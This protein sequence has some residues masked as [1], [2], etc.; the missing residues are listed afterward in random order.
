ME[1]DSSDSFDKTQLTTEGMVSLTQSVVKIGQNV[2]F[3]K[4]QIPPLRE[5]TREARDKSREAL[6]RITDHLRD[7]EAHIH[8]CIEAERQVRQDEKISSIGKI[9]PRLGGIAKIVWWMIGVVVLGIGSAMS[10]AIMTR[11]DAAA[12]STRIENQSSDIQRHEKDI[13]Q[14]EKNQTRDREIFL[15]ELRALPSSFQK[16]S[17][18]DT[19]LDEI[20]SAVGD[21]P[22]TQH[23]KRVL[24]KILKQAKY[25]SGGTKT[26]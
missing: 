22:F 24:Q 5:D 12:N 23:E 4:E 2:K 17:R 6:S 10:F 25:R 13:S 7:K 20:E 15:K 14:I 8:V 21:L 11:A 19:S 1:N 9:E 18:E 26:H 3:I 16:V